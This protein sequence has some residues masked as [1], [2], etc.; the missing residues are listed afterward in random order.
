[1]RLSYEE[2][3]SEIEEA[4]FAFMRYLVSDTLFSHILINKKELWAV[5]QHLL[6]ALRFYAVILFLLHILPFPGAKEMYMKFCR[7]VHAVYY[8]RRRSEKIL[9]CYTK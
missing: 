3:S 2:G 7:V 9:E 5:S 8:L 6:K 1:M 4:D